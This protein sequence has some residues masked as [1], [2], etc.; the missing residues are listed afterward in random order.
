MSKN[1]PRSLFRNALLVVMSLTTCSGRCPH[2]HMHTI[3]E[4]AYNQ[5]YCT[6]ATSFPLCIS[7]QLQHGPAL[8]LH[9]YPVRAI[10]KIRSL[11][12]LSNGTMGSMCRKM[13]Q[14]RRGMRSIIMY[15]HVVPCQNS[16]WSGLSSPNYFE[17]LKGSRFNL[18]RPRSEKRLPQTFTPK[19]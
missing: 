3:I 16:V 10:A 8:R 15:V 9:K 18:H 17:K 4:V 6:L 19:K 5:V 12:S 2:V 13:A 11:F 1:P 14:S 7:V